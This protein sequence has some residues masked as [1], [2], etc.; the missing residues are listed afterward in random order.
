MD[1]MLGRA[2]FYWRNHSSEGLLRVMRDGD[3]KAAATPAF[4][5]L[6]RQP[7]PHIFTALPSLHGHAV[8][9]Q[10]RCHSSKRCGSGKAMANE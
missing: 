6:F 8:T 7:F 10:P 1:S 3:G 4:R 5:M 9:P 2:Q